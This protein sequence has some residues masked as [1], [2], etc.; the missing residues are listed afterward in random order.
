M[1]RTLS[2]LFVA[3]AIVAIGGAAVAWN[4]VTRFRDAPWG[5]PAEKLVEVPPGASPRAVVRLLARAGVLADDRLGWLYV[6]WIRRD[7]RPF[8]AGQYAFAGALRPDEVLDR[9]HRGEVKLYRFTVPEGLR[10]E[11][12]AEIVE[13]SGLAKAVDVARLARDPAVAAALDVP[14]PTL[15]GFLFPDTYAF[16]WGVSPQRIL[17]AMVHRFRE[18]LTAAEARR[19]P[20]VLLSEREVVTLASIVEK[21]TGQPQERPRIACVFQNR[22]RKGMRLQTDPTV[23]YAT[24]LRTGRWSKNISRADLLAPHPYNTYT[25]AGLPPGPIASPGAAAVEAVLAPAACDDLFFVS[26]NDGTHVFCPTLSCHNAAVQR[27]QVEFH[28]KRR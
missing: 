22:L 1:K 19:Q 23:M 25:T 16:A 4:V 26:R 24:F 12:I 5:T 21:E 11:E 7:P 18:V 6:R 15:E 8:K 10:I 28:R 27:W 20:T 17:E 3:I 14:F 2:I 9:I 13:R